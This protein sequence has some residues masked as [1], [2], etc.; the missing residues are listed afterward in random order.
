MFIK[1]CG[2]TTAEAVE[3]AVA[4]G[5]NAVGFVFA[6][7]LRRVTP[8]HAAQ[9]AKS[10]PRNVLKIAVTQ[11]PDQALVD[12]ICERFGPDVLQ[13]DIE[14]LARL[15]IPVGVEVLP[16][17]RGALEGDVPKRLLFEGPISG[18]GAVSNWEQAAQLARRSQLIL[19]G[20]LNAGNIADAILQV[21]PFGVDV[22]SGVEVAAGVKD[23]RRI[24]EFVAAAR[25][26]AIRVETA[27]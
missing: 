16:V 23:S 13:T 14:D 20:G 6:P 12:Q 26:A 22:S 15:K 27:S 2:M 3:T 19:A 10:V 1:I 11:H 24:G 17:V 18:R 25:S 21:R 9:L 7:S 4:Q 8:E 5:V